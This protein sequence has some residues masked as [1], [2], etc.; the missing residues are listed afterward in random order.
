MFYWPAISGHGAFFCEFNRWFFTNSPLFPCREGLK[1][2]I[3]EFTKSSDNRKPLTRAVV[4]E[5]CLANAE[6]RNDYDDYRR[7][8]ILNVEETTV[9]IFLVDFGVEEFAVPLGNLI[10]I[11]KKLIDKLPFQVIWCSI[12]I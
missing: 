10:E 11:P 12:L 8:K 3:L 6:N 1:R 9:N 5:I 2:K 7:A 4:G